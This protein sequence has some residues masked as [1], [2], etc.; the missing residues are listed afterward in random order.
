MVVSVGVSSHDSL[1]G[2]GSGVSH[3]T[4]VAVELS[5]GDA[6][7]DGIVAGGTDSFTLANLTS[8]SYNISL[9]AVDFAGNVEAGGPWAVV[10]VDLDAPVSRFLVEPSEFVRVNEIMVA[11]G[12]S[13]AGV[14]EARL[15]SS[16]DW[17]AANTTTG[18]SLQS[19]LPRLT[20]PP[21]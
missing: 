7:A 13:E 14:T 15:G 3:V 1:G 20:R 11:I 18:V 17:V 6:V 10:E 16:G 21:L 4:V 19:H 5:D 9:S 8:G 12:S 2:S